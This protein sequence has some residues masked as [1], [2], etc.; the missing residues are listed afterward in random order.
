MTE[1]VR[2]PLLVCVTMFVSGAAALAGGLVFE[3]VTV[4]TCALIA[5]GAGGFGTFA[6][7]QVFR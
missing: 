2:L 6:I 4:S 7:F 3:S 1:A 5:M